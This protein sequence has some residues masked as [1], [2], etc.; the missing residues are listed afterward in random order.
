MRIYR[1]NPSGIRFQ[2]YASRAPSFEGVYTCRLP[3][4]NG[5]TLDINI[6]YYRTYPSKYIYINSILNI[7]IKTLYTFSFYIHFFN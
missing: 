5:N 2:N 4:S 1:V 6:A 7:I 3:D